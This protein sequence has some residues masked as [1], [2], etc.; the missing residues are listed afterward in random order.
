MRK[1]G[2]DGQDRLVHVHV[3]TYLLLDS[4]GKDTP[5]RTFHGRE[6]YLWILKAGE[7]TCGPMICRQIRIAKGNNILVV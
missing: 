7:Q 1:D 4:L 6:P 3:R 2:V 5:P